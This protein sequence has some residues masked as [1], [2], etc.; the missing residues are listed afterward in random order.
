MPEAR[1][2]LAFT[3]Q[4]ECT[5]ST[6]IN[7]LYC[8]HFSSAAYPGNLRQP[9]ILIGKGRKEFTDY[10]AMSDINDIRPFPA[11]R[12]QRDRPVRSAS[13]CC[14]RAN[15]CPSPMAAALLAQRLATL[16]VTMPE[17]SAGMIRETRRTRKSS[18]SWP[19][20]GSRSPR[21]AARRLP[22]RPGPRQPGAGDGPGESQ[23]CRK[24]TEPSAGTIVAPR[25]PVG[26]PS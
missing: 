16:G 17:R 7:Y 12:A 26:D 23:A 10:I 5:T 22:G 3:A 4:E 25:C 2:R 8:A 1:R 21:T 14:A 13:S 19:G 20:T 15:V 18:R 9:T 24:T 6:T 11:V